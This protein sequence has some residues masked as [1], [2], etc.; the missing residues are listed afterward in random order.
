MVSSRT[1]VVIYPKFNG[2]IFHR[3]LIRQTQP[4]LATPLVN[5]TITD[6]TIRQMQ[7][8]SATLSPT[9]QVRAMLFSP[10]NKKSCQDHHHRQPF[11]A[12]TITIAILPCHRSLVIA[13]ATAPLPLPLPPLPSLTITQNH[14]L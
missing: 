11:L 4:S 14:D 6:N 5:T 1:V 7:P 9:K 10:L 2:N 12:K 13:I 3:Q 8:A